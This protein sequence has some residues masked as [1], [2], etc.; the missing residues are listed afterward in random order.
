MT[1]E[2][3]LLGVVVAI[4]ATQCCG[5]LEWAA[6]GLI[7]W[8]VRLSYGRAPRG[9][10]RLVEQLRALDNCPVQGAKFL[11]ALGF[12]L[13]GI[14]EW[15]WRASGRSGAPAWEGAGTGHFFGAVVALST[16]LQG[17]GG[18][19]RAQSR[20]RREEF[21]R[22]VTRLRWLLGHPSEA[23]DD[24][25]LVVLTTTTTS[26]CETYIDDR[27]ER[28]AL[29]LVEAAR[30]LTGRLGPRHQPP[31]GSAVPTPTRC[32][33]SATRGLKRCCAN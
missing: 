31:W 1:L 12:A 16:A 28:A 6:R 30:P 5:I 27:N 26:A 18:D 9:D 2:K 3:I 11:F 8:A 13:R 21:D 25:G 15:L 33:N 14:F 29:E 23:F 24:Q 32:S 22:L 19:I 10:I 7:H 20:A 17:F 4:M